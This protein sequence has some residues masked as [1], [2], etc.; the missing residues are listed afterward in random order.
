MMKQASGSVPTGPSDLYLR[1][2][3]GEVSPKRYVARVKKTVD[4]Q[5]GKQAA[6]GARRSAA[7][8]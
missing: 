2:L 4:R 7:T 3:R 1:M 8:E 6:N 5:I